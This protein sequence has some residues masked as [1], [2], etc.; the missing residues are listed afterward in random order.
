MLNNK[1]KTTGVLIS[2]MLVL[3]VASATARTPII[4]LLGRWKGENVSV[5]AGSSNYLYVG[6]MPTK[7]LD[8]SNPNEPKVVGEFWTAGLM[9]DTDAFVK[10]S[11]L[12]TANMNFV[13]ALDISD[14]SN[15]VKLGSIGIE[16]GEG[17][18]S[19][20]EPVGAVGICAEG[21]FAYVS[22]MCGGL[23]VIDI[24]NPKKMKEIARCKTR[25]VAKKIV[26][27]GKYVFIADRASGLGIFDVSDPKSPKETA[28]LKLQRDARGIDIFGE[29]AYV[30]DREG[31]LVIVDISNPKQPKKLGWLATEGA[32][33]NVKAI[34]DY[35]F[36]ANADDGLSVVD[37]SDPQSPKTIKSFPTEDFVSNLFIMGSRLYVGE[38]NAGLSIY[39]IS[40]FMK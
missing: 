6:H 31:G 9:V 12:L 8:V 2:F 26:K 29:K 5:L 11:L 35:I 13:F 38:N 33:W 39:D 1:V 7:V 18:Y 40:D 25:N 36:V 22:A 24:S 27:S 21:N 3:L 17:S 34:G 4:K 32:I 14:P 30:A 37:V 15:P 16:P 28:Y 10:D 20:M 23:I 19:F